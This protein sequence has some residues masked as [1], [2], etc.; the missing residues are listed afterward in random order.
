MMGSCRQRALRRN[1]GFDHHSCGRYLLLG[2]LLTTPAGLVSCAKSVTRQ[3]SDSPATQA[4]SL[5]DE[6]RF[7]TSQKENTSAADE[8]RLADEWGIDVLGV[9]LSAAGYMLDF[10]YRV[11]DPQKASHL[12]A[13]DAKHVLIDEKTGARFL[14]PSPPKVGP[15]RPRP[16]TPTSDRVYWILFANPGRQVKA[17]DSVSVVIGDCT[18]QGL[19]VR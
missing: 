6:Q 7:A 17:G 19:I 10:R 3:S 1:G 15:L 2:L 4:A 14:V 16:E 13:R 12:M 11:T 5:P 18:I 9:Q 8:T